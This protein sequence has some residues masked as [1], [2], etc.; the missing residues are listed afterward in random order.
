[1]NAH[2]PEPGALTTREVEILK[3]M[4]AGQ[5]NSQIAEQLSI[6]EGTVER[7]VHHILH[8]LGVA[9]RTEAALW[10]V[11]QRLSGGDPATP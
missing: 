10:A 9:N 2:P 7:H 1:M 8:K 4:A 3:L 11:R 5:S 6:A